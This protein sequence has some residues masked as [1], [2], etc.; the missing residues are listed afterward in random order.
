MEQLRLGLPPRDTANP[1]ARLMFGLLALVAGLGLIALLLFVVL[2]VAG[3]IVSAALGG[4][5]LAL[6]GVVMMVPFLLVAGSVLIFF[7]R[8]SARRQAS[9]RSNTARH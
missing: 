9:V 5:L 6:A 2:P 8:S 4:I 3:L 1:I 7:S